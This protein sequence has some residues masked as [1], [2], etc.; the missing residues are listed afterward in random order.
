MSY[1]K[2]IFQVEVIANDD[3]LIDA[4]IINESLSEL[5]WA[6]DEDDGPFAG[7][8]TLKENTPLTAKQAADAL[9]SLYVDPI[10]F[11]LKRDGTPYHDPVE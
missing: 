10:S 9:L 6:I 8:I 2:V 4:I 1:R 7:K 5:G 11:G 3:Q